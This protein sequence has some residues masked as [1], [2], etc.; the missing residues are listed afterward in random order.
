MKYLF[1][2]MLGKEKWPL[3]DTFIEAWN[4]MYRHVQ[5]QL[6][7]GNLGY[8]LL[9]TALWIELRDE[10]T[11]SKAPMFFYDARDHAIREYDWSLEKQKAADAQ[12]PIPPAKPLPPASKPRRSK[13]TIKA[14]A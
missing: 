3:R 8:Q 6:E 12:N 4:D 11:C 7:A 13:V 9:E 2:S 5:Q 10:A 14:K 1:E